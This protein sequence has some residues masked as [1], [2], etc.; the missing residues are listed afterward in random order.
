MPNSR[1][2]KT[3]RSSASALSGQV[4]TLMVDVRASTQGFAQ[5]MGA[6]RGAFDSTVVSGFTQGGA[7][8]DSSLSSAI[9]KSSQGFNDFGAVALKV[10]DQIAVQAAK[11]LFFGSGGSSGGGLGGLLG[12]IFGLGGGSLGGLG[13]PGR[14]TGGPVSP[15]QGFVVGERGPELFVPT[16]AGAISANQS[17][18]QDVRISINVNTTSGTEGAQA[19]SRSSRQIASAVR[20]AL[21]QA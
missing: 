15:G 11:S 18:G 8:L 12:G 19:L 1:Y 3:T 21:A 14:A 2:T 17:G 5:D 13:L 4:Q 7:A 9:S 16:S 10:L 6:L 20:R